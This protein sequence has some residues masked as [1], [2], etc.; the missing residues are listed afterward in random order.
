MFAYKYE[1]VVCIGYDKCKTQKTLKNEEYKN[2]NISTER[3][4]SK[5][6]NRIWLISKMIMLKNCA[7]DCDREMM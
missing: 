6:P 3:H 4:F 5:Q 1:F 2:R 7:R